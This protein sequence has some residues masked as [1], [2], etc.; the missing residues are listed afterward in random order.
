LHVQTSFNGIPSPKKLMQSFLLGQ[1]KI[2][3]ERRRE[4]IG[5]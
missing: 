1:A 2:A 5:R 4:K 3:D